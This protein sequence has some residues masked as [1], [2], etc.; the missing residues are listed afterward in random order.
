M[1]KIVKSR[2]YTIEH[3]DS[4]NDVS[5]SIKFKFKPSEDTELK[6]IRTELEKKREVEQMTDLVD[7]VIR[8]AI[9]DCNDIFNE[10]DMTPIKV[11]DD[12]GVP[13]PYIQKLLFDITK[14]YPEFF[15]KVM[16]AYL[17]PKGKN[18]K[19]GQTP[20]SSGSGDQVSATSVKTEPVSQ[21]PVI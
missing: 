1:L 2:E 15:T 5:F 6:R 3:V 14:A 20:V 16:M 8:E 17:G 10:E 7:V 19:T 12:K 21:V 18:L 13:D 9:V 11:M 4:A